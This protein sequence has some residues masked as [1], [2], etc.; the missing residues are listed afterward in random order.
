M[1]RNINNFIKVIGTAQDEAEEHGQQE[2]H[3]SSSSNNFTKAIILNGKKYC[4]YDDSLLRFKPETNAFFCTQC[5]FV[6]DTGPQKNTADSRPSLVTDTSTDNNGAESIS[7]S[8]V[9]MPNSGRRSLL[10]QEEFSDPESRMRQE[11]GYVIIDQNITTNE[12]GTFS[13]PE[14]I[15][16]G[17]RYFGKNRYTS[18]S[19]S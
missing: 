7:M 13:A 18:Y 12:I 10:R 11:K 2:Q 15:R 9:S 8:M 4:P 17:E 16:E 14:A 1:N 19:V 5:P 6:E 3:P